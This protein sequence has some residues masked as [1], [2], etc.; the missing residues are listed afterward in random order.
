MKNGSEN[1]FARGLKRI[2][3]SSSSMIFLI[4][5]ALCLVIGSVN[6]TF[7]SKANIVNLTRTVSYT[8][9]ISGFGTMV[10]I[11]GGLDLSVGS[12]MCLGGFVAA[13]LMKMGVPVAISIILG[14]AAGGI[15]GAFNGFCIVNC[16]IPPMIVTLSTQYIGKGIVCVITEGQPVYPLP[17]SFNAFGN[18]TLFGLS[19]SVYIAIGMCLITAFILKY[20]SFGRYVYAI[21]GNRETARL[22]GINVTKVQ[23][24]VYI[25]TA[26]CA[27]F[28]GIIVAARVGSAQNTLGNQWESKFI[29]AVFV[30]GTSTLGGAGS[31]FGTVLGAIVMALIDNGLVLMRV[32]TY[33]TNIITGLLIV[34][35]VGLDTMK[36]SLELRRK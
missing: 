16:K 14:V 3:R 33:W 35:S 30:G 22:S 34:G 13:S 25:I 29:A 19:Y 20:T 8:M 15:V 5:V 9:I 4:V 36:R 27:S 2:F 17:E 11:M 28:C 21:G 31:V 6:S 12:V 26:M 1:G 7:Y 18:N 32:S 23:N 24:W 10:F